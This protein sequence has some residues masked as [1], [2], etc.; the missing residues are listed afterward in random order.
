MNEIMMTADLIQ[1]GVSANTQRAYRYSIEKLE[2]W[3]GERTMDDAVLAEYITHLRRENRP[4]R[5]RRWLLLL[6][7][8]RRITGGKQ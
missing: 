3:Q 2:A 4:Q 8:A 5:F 1:A 6:S 7:G